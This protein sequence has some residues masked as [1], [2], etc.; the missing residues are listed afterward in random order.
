MSSN[1]GALVAAV[2]SGYGI[3]AQSGLLVSQEIVPVPANVGL[4]VLPEVDFVMVG[5]TDQLDGAARDLSCLIIENI[6]GLAPPGSRIIAGQNWP[7]DAAYEM[8]VR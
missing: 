3:F 8:D 5:A 7:E 2:R 1:L 4:P 6:E